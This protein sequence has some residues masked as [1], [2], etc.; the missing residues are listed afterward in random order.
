MGNNK[1]NK[2]KDKIVN[3]LNDVKEEA[4]PGKAYELIQEIFSEV[5]NEYRDQTVTLTIPGKPLSV[6]RAY[7][8][9]KNQHGMYASSKMKRYKG[10]V[11]KRAVEEGVKNPYPDPAE[12]EIDFYFDRAH[13]SNK[14][15]NGLSFPD[16]DNPLKPLK[17]AL[18]GVMYHDDTQIQGLGVRKH[19]TKDRPRAE[20][21]MHLLK[22]S[23]IQKLK[24]QGEYETARDSIRSWLDL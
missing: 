15:L 20:V 5:K 4:G 1:F 2:E 24:N 11:E 13:R 18:E 6:N 22:S 12:L 23:Q 7:K 16:V 8:T 21:K 9:T 14:Y 10:K 3:I 19:Y 17:D